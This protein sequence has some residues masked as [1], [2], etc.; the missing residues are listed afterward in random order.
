[1]TS[2]EAIDAISERMGIPPGDLMTLVSA[3]SC[4]I[5]LRD[6]LLEIVIGKKK[7][8]DQTITLQVTNHF[9]V[10]TMVSATLQSGRVTA[11]GEVRGPVWAQ[12]DVGPD[13]GTFARVKAIYAAY[14]WLIAEL[15]STHKLTDFTMYLLALGYA[16]GR[17][18]EQ[19]RFTRDEINEHLRTGEVPHIRVPPHEGESP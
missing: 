8:D 3:V 13:E 15:P 9:G 5:D 10:A 11:S 7:P 6:E 17:L 18:V 14:G 16:Q 19:G 2:D 4:A 12:I 1:M